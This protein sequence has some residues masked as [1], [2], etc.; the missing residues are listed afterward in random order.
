[1]VDASIQMLKERADDMADKFQ[2]KEKIYQDKMTCLTREMKNN[3]NDLSKGITELK[4]E[5]SATSNIATAMRYELSK[6]H[7]KEDLTRLELDRMKK[8][9]LIDGGDLKEQLKTERKH[10]ARLEL[11]IEAL[12]EQIYKHASELKAQK[13]LQEQEREEFKSAIRKTQHELWRQ[14]FAIYSVAMDVDSLFLFFAERLA[15][16]AGSRQCHND[17]LR[18][19]GAIEIAAVMCRGTRKEMKTPAVQVLA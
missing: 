19:N 3:E 8:M 11:I 6:F 4:N 9:W 1:M 18:A 16:L 15:N 7:V 2:A 14:Q 17:A 5:L 13:R 10:S 12:K